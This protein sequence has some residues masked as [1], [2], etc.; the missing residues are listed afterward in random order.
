MQ[1][2]PRFFLLLLV[3]S[4]SLPSLL[5]QVRDLGDVS[6]KI[7]AK[8]ISVTVSGAT[9][10]L[11]QL[12]NVAFNAHGRFRRVSSG[13]AFDIRFAPAA[14]GQVEAQIRVEPKSH[15]AAP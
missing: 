10:E 6:I 7:D 4:L 12:A 13:G 1:N 15:P 9:P 11:D 2:P 8:T 14:G 3:L 5:A